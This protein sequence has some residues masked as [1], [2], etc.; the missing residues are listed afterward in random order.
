M[1]SPQVAYPGL[2]SPRGWLAVAFLGVVL[3][4]VSQ[5]FRLYPE[6]IASVTGSTVGAV[7]QVLGVTAGLGSILFL[8]GLVAALW[9]ANLAAGLSPAGVAGLAL[10]AAGIGVLFLFEIAR[11]LDWIRVTVSQVRDLLNAAEVGDIIGNAFAFAGLA[12]LGVGL[13]QAAGLFGR[14]EEELPRAAASAEETS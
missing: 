6:W 9:R 12:F 8:S 5:V 3:Y 13:A 11:V 14:P 4:L 1:A 2:R 7:R 10:G